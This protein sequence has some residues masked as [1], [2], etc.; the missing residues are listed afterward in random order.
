[1]TVGGCGQARRGQCGKRWTYVIL[2]LIKIKKKK[3][4]SGSGMRDTDIVT[5]Q[6]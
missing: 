1:M 4:T 2:T 3:K 6:C 5:V